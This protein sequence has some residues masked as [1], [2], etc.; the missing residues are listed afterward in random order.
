MTFDVYIPSLNIIIE[1]H[2]YQHYYDHYMFGDVKP[3]KEQDKKRRAACVYHNISY[4]EVPYWWQHDK[5]SVMAIIHQV[6]PD[7]VPQSLVTP[8]HYQKQ[9]K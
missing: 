4:L 3:Y 6:R 2:G 1:Y 8:F 9:H 5:E 7:I